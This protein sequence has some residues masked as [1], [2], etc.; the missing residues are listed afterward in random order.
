[1]LLD[2]FR[3]TDLAILTSLE[4][5]L[6]TPEENYFEDSDAYDKLRHLSNHSSL[7][8]TIDT[9]ILDVV[10]VWNE[11]LHARFATQ[12][13]VPGLRC[14][15]ESMDIADKHL[16]C[17]RQIAWGVASQAEDAAGKR[18]RLKIIKITRWIGPSARHYSTLR[19]DDYDEIQASV[20][21]MIEQE[22]EAN[23]WVG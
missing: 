16:D 18:E 6:C 9:H 3:P 12:L 7:T 13:A 22:L 11:H 10:A 21:P 8:I 17:L 14:S 19:S 4:L 2:M 15:E 20:L 1:M 23:G 5:N